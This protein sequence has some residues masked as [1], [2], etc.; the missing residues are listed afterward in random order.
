MSALKK[1]PAAKPAKSAKLAKAV[2]GKKVAKVPAKVVKAPAKPA[3]KPVKKVAKPLRKPA[4]KAAPVRRA[5]VKPVGLKAKGRSANLAPAAAPV[6]FQLPLMPAHLVAAVKALDEKKAVD[7]RVLQ[8]GQLSSVADFLVVATGNSE[9]HLRALRIELERVVEAAG[10]KTRTEAHKDSGWSVVDAF[11]VVFHLF[12]D[13]TR[14]SYGLESLWKD[15]LDI[16]VA[17]ILKA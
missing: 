1:K 15:G 14:R 16:P 13:D 11:D 9:P 3:A 2:K 12:R 5:A 8:L 10:S 17:A 6:A 4:A 7:L